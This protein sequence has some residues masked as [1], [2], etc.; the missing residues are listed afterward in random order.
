VGAAAGVLSGETA[1][2]GKRA[3]KRHF[4]VIVFLEADDT[5]QRLAGDTVGVDPKHF[6]EIGRKRY[7]AQLLVGSPFIASPAG[8]GFSTAAEDRGK[9]WAGGSALGPTLERQ[10]D[11]IALGRGIDPK[12]DVVIGRSR[13]CRP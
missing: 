2:S 11:L 12:L 1:T 8:L 5:R 13:E 4:A 6:G 9:A 10:R 3:D 7:N